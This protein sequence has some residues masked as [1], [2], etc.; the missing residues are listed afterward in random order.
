MH[1]ND[2]KYSDIV[3][4]VGCAYNP[5]RGGVAQ[6]LYNYRKYIF[7]PFN[8]VVDSASGSRLYKAFIFFTALLQLC[9]KLIFGKY[10]IVHIHTSS[11]N[12][13]KRSSYFVSISKF[14]NKKVILHI[15]GGGFAE[16]YKTN[17]QWVSKVLNKTDYIIAL[18][19]KWK[20]FFETIASVPLVAVVENLIAPIQREQKKSFHDNKI[21]LLFLG[22]ITE[23]K[24][25]FDLMSLVSDNINYFYENNIV[26]HIGG[27]GEVSRLLEIINSHKLDELVKFEGWVDGTNKIEL[28]KKVDA[29]ILPSHAEG[30]PLS[31]LEA[32]SFS[33]PIIASNVGG[34]P[35]IVENDVN[36]YI[37]SPLDNLQLIEAISK[38]IVDPAVRERMGIASYSRVCS[39]FP[40]SV[41]VKLGNIYE[42]L[43]DA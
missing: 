3:L 32:M 21:H 13:F 43:L 34:I 42:K 18:S 33:L 12:S 7:N 38:I 9:I 30:L 15:H 20:L 27:N 35:E 26:I 19:M 28:L 2:N 31:I 4:F 17:P 14:F 23:D 6:V 37:I 16:Y 24:G 1:I 40:K 5:P 41:S 29:F 39:Y 8:I 11:Y 25:V 10:K 36:G 22:L